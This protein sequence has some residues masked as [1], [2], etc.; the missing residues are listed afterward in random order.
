MSGPPSVVSRPAIG[1]AYRMSTVFIVTAVA[2]SHLKA[3]GMQIRAFRARVR[4]DSG[5]IRLG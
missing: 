4:S 1:R 2:G 5:V 3:Q